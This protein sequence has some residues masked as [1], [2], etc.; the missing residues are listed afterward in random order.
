M[1]G[2]ARAGSPGTTDK[3]V[4]VTASM[5]ELQHPSIDTSSPDNE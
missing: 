1:G 5:V 4:T 3:D 2:G